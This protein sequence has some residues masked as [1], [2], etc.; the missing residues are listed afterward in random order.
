MRYE[1]LLAK[2][3]Q[4]DVA[5]L[6]G[7]VGVALVFQERERADEFGSSLCWFDD[8]VD[9]ASLGG[10][11]RIGKLIFQFKDARASRSF[12]VLSLIQF[13]P[14]KHAHRAFR[15][16]H[17]NLRRGPGEIDVGANVFG[18][19]HAIGAAVGLASYHGQL[20]NGCFGKRIQQLRAVSDDAAVLL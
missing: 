4:R 6:S 3:L 19:H 20:R 1:I 10:H 13:S 11:V 12:L 2:F 7:R 16:H 17:G 15:S 18:S 9:E 8:F 5:V 14:I